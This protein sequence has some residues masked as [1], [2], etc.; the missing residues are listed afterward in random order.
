M[1]TKIDI[2]LEPE[3]IKKLEAEA[4]RTGLSLSRLIENALEEK[5]LKLMKGGIK[6]NDKYN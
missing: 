4:Y 6:Q 1:K 2:Y 5:Y 3:I